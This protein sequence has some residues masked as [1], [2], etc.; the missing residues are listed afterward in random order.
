MWRGRARQRSARAESRLFFHFVIFQGFARRK[1]FLA[2]AC[3][4][5][6]EQ[7]SRPSPPTTFANGWIGPRER[8][9]SRARYT[10]YCGFEASETLPFPGAD[11][12]FSSRCGAI[13]GRLR[14]AVR[15]S[16]AA[17]PAS[18]AR[19][20]GRPVEPARAKSRFLPHFVSFQGFAR[21]KISLSVA[22]P[23]SCSARPARLRRERRCLPPSRAPTLFRLATCGRARAVAR[24]SSPRSERCRRFPCAV[25]ATREVNRG[26][27]KDPST[28][29]F[30][31]KAIFGFPYFRG[32]QVTYRN[33]GS[34]RLPVSR[35]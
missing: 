18:E 30:S 35:P 28:D 4:A 11:L 23:I 22:A 5:A 20:F 1:I 24:S 29:W 19:A 14:F 2:A 16:R 33:R 32:C 21:R 15:P 12:I 27:C 31:Q 34:L 25:S 8:W 9:V 6:V 13:S 10:R 26:R 3:A 7:R 17:I